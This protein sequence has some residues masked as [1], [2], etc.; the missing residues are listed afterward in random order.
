M[1]S[2]FVN[3]FNSLAPKGKRIVVTGIL[4]QVDLQETV[5]GEVIWVIR[6]T[7]G[8]FKADGTF[9]T[10]T[11]VHEVTEETLLDEIRKGISF[12]ADQIDW[13]VL[14]D[15]TKPPYV[16]HVSP[17]NG[18]D[19]VPIYANVQVRVKDAFPTVGIDPSTIKL[20][21]NGIEIT[22]LSI[23]GVD[24]EYLITWTPP[25]KFD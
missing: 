17:V 13:G 4:E 22:D 12:I 24:N 21:V 6:L 25:R 16:S 8:F 3:V 5:D 9:A 2:F 18:D 14:E 15:D 10:P 11:Y 1:A 19:N 23:Q 7:T 20:K